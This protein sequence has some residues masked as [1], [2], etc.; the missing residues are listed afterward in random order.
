M[1]EDFFKVLLENLSSLIGSEIGL[2]MGVDKEMNKLSNTL[3]TIQNV[4]KDAEDKQFQSKSIQNWLSKLHGIAFEIEDILD[5]CATEVSKLKR[6]GGKFNM[7][8]Y[9]FKYKIAR[10]IKEAVEKL[11]ALAEDRHR[12]HLQEII[13]RQPNQVDWSRETGS[14]LNEPDHVYGRDKEKEKIVEIL[15]KEVKDCENLSVL[16][17]IGVGGL[18]KTTLAQLV[19]NDERVSQHFVIKLWICVSDNFD[20]KAILGAVVESVTG[21]KSNLENLDSL[22]HRVRHELN[23]KRYLLILDDVWNENQEDWVK[24]KSILA[25][26]SIGASIIVTT[27]LEKVA[28][29]MGTLPA[30]SLTILTE[31]EC[32]LLFKLRSFGQ[33]TDDRHLNLQAIGRRIVKKCGGVPLAAKALGGILRFKREEKDW[34][35]VEESHVWNIPE[36]ENSILPVLRLSYRHLPFVLK[37]CF[38]YCTFFPKDYVFDKKELIFHWMAHGCILSNG[39]EEVEDVGD[40]IWKELAFRSFFQEVRSRGGKTTFKMHDLI[41]DLAQSIME[42]KISGTETKHNGANAS[43]NKIRQINSKGVTTLLAKATA[44]AFVKHMTCRVLILAA[45]MA[46]ALRNTHISIAVAV[47]MDGSL[48]ILQDVDK[49]GD[50]LNLV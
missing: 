12:F 22:Q 7:K 29:I 48:I 25:C 6:K 14:I 2:I 24:L 44:L 3:T 33:L 19:Y 13:V 30:N 11:E 47:S 5:E 45:E 18:G 49:V 4:L 26:G 34:I 39:K 20:L 32:W 41:H 40:Q 42:N 38:S 8:K 35:R 50:T 1:A 15:V 46:R 21:D 23:E 17:I 16:P 28:E 31:E 36:E 43:D 37:R 27:R 9:L 10:R